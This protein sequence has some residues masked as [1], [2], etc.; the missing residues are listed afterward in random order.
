MAEAGTPEVAPQQEPQQLRGAS[1]LLQQQQT[2]AGTQQQIAQSTTQRNKAGLNF[3]AGPSVMVREF[4]NGMKSKQGQQGST[5]AAGS[6]PASRRVPRLPFVSTPD[7][8]NSTVSRPTAIGAVGA[9]RPAGATASS[10]EQGENLPPSRVAP[11]AEPG[12][13]TSSPDISALRSGPTQG[14][15][16]VTEGPIVSSETVAGTTFVTT[17]TTTQVSGPRQE[18]M[19][20]V[21]LAEDLPSRPQR[22]VLGCERSGIRSSL[23]CTD[24]WVTPCALAGFQ[25]GANLQAVLM[26]LQRAA[27]PCSGTYD[28]HK[29]AVCLH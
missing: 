8:L 26:D 6:K 25:R 18:A 9:S 29:T 1:N 5:G 3:H 4:F 2:E 10:L 24:P 12:I 27:S 21:P 13:M 28:G 16:A 7:Q 20:I 15:A 19:E 23:N 22:Y 11:D 14:S 17:T